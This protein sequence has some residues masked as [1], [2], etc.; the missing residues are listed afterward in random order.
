MIGMRT[1]ATT[2]MSTTLTTT[3]IAGVIGAGIVGG[4]FYAFSTFV[5]PGL[6]RLPASEGVHAMQQIN[7]TA[8]QPA[9][10]L[11]FMGTTALC[12]YLGVRGFIDRGETRATLLMAGSLLYLVGVF[13][14]TVG[15]NVPL[16]DTLATVNPHA[17]GVAAHWQHF[18]SGWEWANHL[19]GAASIASSGAFIAALLV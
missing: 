14:L 3:T 7:V 12:L 17:P 11:A 2:E 18:L 19:R 5:M 4:V 6:K 1:T 9:F 10:M 16:N 8:Q 13:G 15:Q